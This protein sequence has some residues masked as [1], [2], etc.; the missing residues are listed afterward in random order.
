MPPQAK[1]HYISQ[2]PGSWRGA[3]DRFSVMAFKGT[4][5]TTTASIFQPPDCETMHFCRL[6]CF[7]RID[8]ANLYRWLLERILF[9]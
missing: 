8:L 3:W 7:A 4:N 6:W 2:N 1:G 5:L 9:P